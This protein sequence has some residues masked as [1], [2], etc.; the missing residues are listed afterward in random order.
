[1]ANANA[2]LAG[3]AAGGTS[4]MELAYF[5][6]VGAVAPTNATSALS[7]TNASAVQSIAITGTP[8][9]GTFN[10][11][12]G[13]QTATG[14]VYNA[15]NTA[16]QTALQALSSIG[17][18][19]VTVTGSSPTYTVTFTGR[20]ASQPLATMTASGAF[21]GGTSPAIAVTTT[22]PGSMAWVSAGYV[23]EDGMEMTIKEDSNDIRAYA[24]FPV[25]RKIVKA[26]ETSFKLTFLETNIVT[27]AIRA[28]YPLAGLT[29]LLASGG[30][31]AVTEGPARTTR[32]SM[33]IDVTDGASRIR[34]YAP[35]V[36]VTD[37]ESESIKAGEAL[38]YGVTFSAYP[39]SSGNSVYKYYPSI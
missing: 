35:I 7:T 3:I 10:L 32:Y 2:V 39:D 21:T 29:S 30:E 15:T 18:G 26:S 34:Y 24:S 37:R 5:N 11:S 27:Q 9:G 1:M 13:G 25:V 23:S 4:G 33:S 16:I 22:T 20:L 28:R 38:T 12:F 31:I 6:V 36:E 8:T 14:I 19:N 17:T